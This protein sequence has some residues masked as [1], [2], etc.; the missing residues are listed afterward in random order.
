[1]ET[2]TG[3]LQCKSCKNIHAVF[4][5]DNKEATQLAMAETFGTVCPK[6]GKS[7]DTNSTMLITIWGE[8]AKEVLEAAR[9]DGILYE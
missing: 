7:I 1:M 6:C 2:F 3:A 9:K 5:L 4:P 8:S